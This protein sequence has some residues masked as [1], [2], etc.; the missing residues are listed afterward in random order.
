[1]PQSG[2]SRVQVRRARDALIKQGRHPSVEAI[3]AYLGNTGS[4]STISR[5]LKELNATASAAAASMQAPELNSVI[6]D[7]KHTLS[8]DTESRICAERSTRLMQQQLHRLEHIQYQAQLR[9]LRESAVILTGQL[10]DALER[11]QLH[12]VDQRSEQMQSLNEGLEQLQAALRVAQSAQVRQDTC[13]PVLQD[14]QSDELKSTVDELQGQL[15]S[16]QLALTDC[17]A[18]IQLLLLERTGLR[19]RL[20]EQLLLVRQLRQDLQL[21]GAQVSQLQQMLERVIPVAMG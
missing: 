11:S 13:R 17:Q 3:R 4:N 9:Q 2:I 14:Q 15:K 6:D 8:Q 18:Q 20:R 16:Q 7:S 1:M 12:L 19:A 5:Y 10:Q 21:R